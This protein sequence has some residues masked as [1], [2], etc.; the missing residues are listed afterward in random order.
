MPKA[1]K[2]ILITVSVS[3][4]V[5]LAA[6]EGIAR[7]IV[8]GPA[9]IAERQRVSISHRALSP[10][11]YR[12]HPFWGYVQGPAEKINNQGFQS[13]VSYPYRKG[14]REFVVGVFGASVAEQVWSSHGVDQRLAPVLKA[15]GYEHVTF[16][17]FALPGWRQPQSFNAL[18]YALPSIDMAIQVDGFNDIIHLN[19]WMLKAQPAGYPWSNIYG[20][21]ARTETQAETTL[22]RAELI[23]HSRAI[24]AATEWASRPPMAWSRLAHLIWRAI[25]NSHVKKRIELSD[26]EAN[27]LAPDWS[28]LEPLKPAEKEEAYLTWME[29]LTRLAHL[30]CSAKNKLFFH[31][32]QPNQYDEGAKPL[33]DE[34]RTKLT[35]L[36]W[37]PI[38]TSHYRRLDAMTRRLSSEGVSSFFLGRIFSQV[39][40]TVYN[41]DC[42]HFNPHGLDLLTRAIAERILASG[43]LDKIPPVN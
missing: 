25:V 40:E 1:T 5:G 21:L 42:C 14:P 8:S 37:R 30:A 16:L 27:E 15:K 38:V 22:R 7:L 19:E 11:A 32:V 24:A 2:R 39:P 29:D 36:P 35:P 28:G 17:N 6:A 13:P 34:E 9:A 41:D 26:A 33:S 10:T 12:L 18:T 43:K 20:V 4:L 31:F 23:R 3:I